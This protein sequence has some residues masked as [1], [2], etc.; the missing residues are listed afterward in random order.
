MY[1]HFA[2]P[3]EEVWDATKEAMNGYVK[4]DVLSANAQLLQAI[5]KKDIPTYAS[6][7]MLEML[8]ISQ[9]VHV[10]S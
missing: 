2:Q 10:S 4:N 6:L 3:V 8:S 5:E 1:R 7:T 9:D